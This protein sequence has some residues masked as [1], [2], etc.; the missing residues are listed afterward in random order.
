MHRI[1]K[2]SEF[3]HV[4]GFIRRSLKRLCAPRVCHF[5]VSEDDA[6]LG[7]PTKATSPVASGSR[8]SITLTKRNSASEL[9][10][11]ADF[12]FRWSLWLDLFHYVC[13]EVAVKI[14][15]NAHTASLESRNDQVVAEFQRA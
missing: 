7:N 12:D 8:K 2:V 6:G 9:A 1:A 5:P 10:A 15:E 3:D 4:Y 14:G 13:Y 11:Q